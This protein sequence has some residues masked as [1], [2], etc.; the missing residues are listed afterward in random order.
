[1]LW[2]VG[3]AEWQSIGLWCAFATG[4]ASL[5]AALPGWWDGRAGSRR[6]I[7]K[8]VTIRTRRC[9][10]GGGAAPPGSRRQGGCSAGGAG[11]VRTLLDW[12]AR[13]A[14]F[15][16][17]KCAVAVRE[18]SA[19]HRREAGHGRTSA[20]SARGSAGRARRTDRQSATTRERRESGALQS[21]IN[22]YIMILYISCRRPGLCG[23]EE[24]GE[25]GWWRAGGWGAGSR[26]PVR[27]ETAG[28]RSAVG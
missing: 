25:V 23:G 28:N 12:S 4:A 3:V 19:R 9:G 6:S 14:G 8:A 16:R 2:V 24:I 11:R 10:T 21:I 5:A 22:I 15:G 18:D 26:F 1:M 20:R 7:S 27:W 17:G 13:I